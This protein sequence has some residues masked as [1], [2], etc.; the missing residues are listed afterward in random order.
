MKK[1]T[2][3]KTPTKA[4]RKKLDVINLKLSA[5][6]LKHLKLKAKQ[7]AEGNLS[8]FLRHAALRYIPKKGEAISFKA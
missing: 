3:K 2:A 6:T 1:K 5:A 8:A 4:K 7:F